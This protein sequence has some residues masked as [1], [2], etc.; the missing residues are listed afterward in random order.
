V[1]EEG[2]YEAEVGHVTHH[3]GLNAA[4]SPRADP[5]RDARRHKTQAT[6]GITTY[7]QGMT[8]GGR[9]RWL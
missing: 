1:A 3:W 9:R 2:A 7:Y 6:A 8:L 5:T 4:R